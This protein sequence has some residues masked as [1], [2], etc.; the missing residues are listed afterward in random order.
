MN[1][2]ESRDS[3]YVKGKKVQFMIFDFNSI[4][5]ICL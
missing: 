5:A 4:A 3:V 2:D 1:Y